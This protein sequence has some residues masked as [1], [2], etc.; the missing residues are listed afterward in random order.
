MPRTTSFFV[1][2]ALAHS[3]LMRVGDCVGIGD[4]AVPHGPRREPDLTEPIEDRSP[5]RHGDLCRTDARRA[6]VEADGGTTSHG[7][8][9]SPATTVQWLFPNAFGVGWRRLERRRG[10]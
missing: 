5:L 6:D 8:H 7:S 9:P 3:C 2:F 4:L 1:N 10:R